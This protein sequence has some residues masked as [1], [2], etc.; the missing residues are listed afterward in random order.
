MKTIIIE[1]TEKEAK[2]ISF[3]LGLGIFRSHSPLYRKH[4]DVEEL[5]KLTLFFKTLF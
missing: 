4:F 1:L 2:I 3:C 5:D